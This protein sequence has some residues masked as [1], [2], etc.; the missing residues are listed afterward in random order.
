[1]ERNHLEA[2][3]AGLCER[4]SR[5]SVENQLNVVNAVE[6]LLAEYER[7]LESAETLPTALEQGAAESKGG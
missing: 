1:M 7:D 5:L 4:C 3:F 6:A 2:T